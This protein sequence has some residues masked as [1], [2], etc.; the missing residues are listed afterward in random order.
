MVHLLSVHA[1]DEA[2]IIG[3]LAH[4]GHGCLPTRRFARAA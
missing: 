1:L 2:N 4:V 3:R